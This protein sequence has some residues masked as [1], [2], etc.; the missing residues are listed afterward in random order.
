MSESPKKISPIETVQIYTDWAN[1]YLEKVKSKRRIQDLQTDIIDGVALADVIEAVT[2]HRLCDVNRKPKTTAQMCDNVTKCL[3]YVESIGVPLDGICAK[4]VKDGNLKTVLSLFF[5]LSRYKQQ[6]KQLLQQAKQAQ[7]THTPELSHRPM[8]TTQQRSLP[9]KSTSGIPSPMSTPSKKPPDRKGQLIPPSVGIPGNGPSNLRPP[10]VHSESSSRS[11][12]PSHPGVQQQTGIS[13]PKSI[14]APR[15]RIGGASAHGPTRG[16]QKITPVAPPT[17]PNN[18]STR[19][20]QQTQ[21]PSQKGSMLEKLKMFKPPPEKPKSSGSKRTSSSSGF[22]SARSERSDSSTSLCNEPKNLESDNREESLT[23]TPDSILNSGPRN[24]AKAPRGKIGKPSPTAKQVS[25][26]ISRGREDHG[27]RV[28][29]SGSRS[30]SGSR[31]RS[32]HSSERPSSRDR[33]EERHSKSRERDLISIKDYGPLDNL[34]GPEIVCAPVKQSHIATRTEKQSNRR[35]IPQPTVKESVVASND[36]MTSSGS[37]IPKPTA[38]VKGT[39]KVVSETKCAMVTA[40]PPLK[41]T[42]SQRVNA[43]TER[44]MQSS[45]SG[46]SLSVQGSKSQISSPSNTLPRQKSRCRELDGSNVALVSPMPSSSGSSASSSSPQAAPASSYVEKEGDGADQYCE[47][48]ESPRD[49]RKLGA[50]TPKF[51]RKEG[52]QEV[53]EKKKSEASAAAESNLGEEA[54][55]VLMSIK[56]MQPLNRNTPYGYIRSLAMSTRHVAPSLHTQKVAFQVDGNRN[57]HTFPNGFEP[58]KMPHGF[59]R[60]YLSTEEYADQDGLEIPSGYVS[61]GDILRA[62]HSLPSACRKSDVSDIS[63][64]GDSLDGYL[65]EGGA[66]LYARRLASLQNGRKKPDDSYD[67]S[68]SI[69]SSIS[70]CLNELSHREN[71]TKITTQNMLTSGM[72]HNPIHAGLATPILGRKERSDSGRNNKRTLDPTRAASMDRCLQIDARRAPDYQRLKAEQIRE[73]SDSRERRKQRADDGQSGDDKIKKERKFVGR[74]D[75]GD[76]DK[77]GLSYLGGA[78]QGITN[79][80]LPVGEPSTNV[81]RSV[82]DG[83][84]IHA[85]KGVPPSFGYIKRSNSGAKCKEELKKEDPKTAQ[86]SIVP[87]LE[88]GHSLERPRT[89]LKCSSGI[90]TTGDLNSTCSDSEYASPIWSANITTKVIFFDYPHSKSA[91]PKYPRKAA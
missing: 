11:T 79:L 36:A 85:V 20:K 15:G 35:S 73:R 1:H 37:G 84:R 14:P 26:K 5:A 52:T 22:S 32:E 88:N 21:L 71:E 28:S 42:P 2:S 27:L 29:K 83:R 56:P 39:S 76:D 48:N 44:S 60:Q 90:Q 24:K 86:V 91:F 33:H 58:L 18:S 67:D 8:A 46:T 4:D 81:P 72:D 30:G 31:E 63:A 3:S 78:A 49:S 43:E 12:S 9:V 77:S 74:K 51:S 50:E 59:R 47:D 87:K 7:M 89:K 69:A 10:T 65:S 13:Q 68:S 70:D 82:V 57:S 16:S 64:N 61:D 75:P 34:P 19:I 53:E 25:P 38:L 66:S 40:K 17:V 55:D 54:E 23:P 41:R 80:E 62:P 45:D 6:Q